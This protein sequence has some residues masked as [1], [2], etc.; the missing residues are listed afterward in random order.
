MHKRIRQNKLTL[1]IFIT[2]CA[3][4]TV[5]VYSGKTASSAPYLSSQAMEGEKL[6]QDNN[7]ASCHQI[8]GLGGYLGDDLTNVISNPHKG[9]NYV[10]AFLN[11]GSKSM[12]K[13]NFTEEEK[14][15]IVQFLSH[16]DWTGYYPN[17]DAELGKDGWV[18]IKYK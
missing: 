13:F 9:E 2:V 7:C 12:P 8:Y 3:V 16:V 10:K 18:S 17:V 11:A 4:Y 6:W 5:I 14:E 15:Q 1:M